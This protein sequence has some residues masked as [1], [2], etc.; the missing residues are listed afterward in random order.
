MELSRNQKEQ[1]RPLLQKQ[2]INYVL[3]PIQQALSDARESLGISDKIDDKDP[4]EGWSDYDM[5]RL[6]DNY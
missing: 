2:K 6:G 1:E 5:K 4:F 3:D